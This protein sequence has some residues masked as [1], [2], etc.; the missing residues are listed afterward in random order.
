MNDVQKKRLFILC[1]GTWQD[2]VNSKY[3]LTNVATLARCLSPVD[4]DNC[5]QLVYYDN[6][7]GNVTSKISVGIDGATGRGISAKIR[8]AFSFLSHYYNFDRLNRDEAD[9][10]VL[11]GFSRGAFAVQCIASFMSQI[12]LLRSCHLYYLRGLYTLWS[13]QDFKRFGPGDPNPVGT[14]LADYVKKLSDEGILYRVKIKALVVWDTVSALGLPIHPP[15]RPLSFVGKQV[16]SIVENAFQALALDERR[17]KFTP[18]VWLSKEEGASHVKQ[19]WFRGTHADVGGNGDAALG[20]VTL[21]WVLGQLRAAQIGIS[22]ENSE[23]GKHLN[24][25]FLEW[26][27]DINRVFGQFKETSVLSSISGPGKPTKPAAYWWLLGMESRGKYLGSRSDD[28]HSVSMQIHFS[29]RLAMANG[30][31]CAPLSKWRTTFRNDKAEW[32][33]GASVIP[34]CELSR[35]ADEYRISDELDEYGWIQA[36]YKQWYAVAST[37]RSVFAQELRDLVMENGVAWTA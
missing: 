8:N 33:S 17:R 37:E 23:V 28:D 7:V 14:T 3:P 36:W 35:T 26:G 22:I 27:F 4:E 9:E 15:P 29:V 10:I 11:A 16:P 24:Q 30:E 13:H 18:R 20:A 12:G 25:K 31:K 32:I 1:D 5:L 34:E 6:G 19:C 21:I 2:G